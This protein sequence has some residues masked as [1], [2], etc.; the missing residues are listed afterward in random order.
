MDGF[1]PKC[2]F[3]ASRRVPT[4]TLS[5]SLDDH[6]PEPS[7]AD[8][9]SNRCRIGHPDPSP[10]PAPRLDDPVPEAFARDFQ[11]ST[12]ARPIAPAMLDGLVEYAAAGHA[13]H[14]EEP[15][16]FARDLS[17]FIVSLAVGAATV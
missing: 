5:S 15:Q 16:R 8:P 17:R 14:W 11:Q 2:R 7:D 10:D 6:L 3:A 4:L 13:M 1:L 12:L 9:L